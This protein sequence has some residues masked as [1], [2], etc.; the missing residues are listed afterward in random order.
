LPIRPTIRIL[1]GVSELQADKTFR[2]NRCREFEVNSFDHSTNRLITLAR[3]WTDY[4]DETGYPQA[5]RLIFDS[6]ELDVGRRIKWGHLRTD[7]QTEPYIKA[8]IVDEH[9]GQMKGLGR[10]FVEQYPEFT[11]DE[12]IAKIFK[13]CQTH[14]ARSITKMEKKGLSKGTTDF[15]FF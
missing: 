5:F 6:A 1:F 3:V 2:R 13:V 11:S 8:I 10:Y 7:S 15:Q 12:H 4:E 9:G 14:Y